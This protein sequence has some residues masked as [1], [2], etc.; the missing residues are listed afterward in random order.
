[1]DLWLELQVYVSK[2]NLF[3]DGRPK[4]PAFWFMEK[5]VYLPLDCVCFMRMKTHSAIWIDCIAFHDIYTWIQA[6]GSRIRLHMPWRIK[7]KPSNKIEFH[8]LLEVCFGKGEMTKIPMHS[9]GTFFKIIAYCAKIALHVK[10]KNANIE[11]CQNRQCLVLEATRQ[12]CL[13]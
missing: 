8:S 12:G 9:L 13:N 5:S 11:N 2:C 10:E 7:N 4:V 1:M 3:L 6:A